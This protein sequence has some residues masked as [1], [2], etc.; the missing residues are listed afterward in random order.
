MY[1]VMYDISQPHADQIYFGCVSFERSSTICPGV[2]VV[3][4]HDAGGEGGLGSNFTNKLLKFTFQI[5]DD[6]NEHLMYVHVLYIFPSK[7]RTIYKPP[8]FYLF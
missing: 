5:C 6:S 4:E 8:N 2:D 3:D 1:V 7:K